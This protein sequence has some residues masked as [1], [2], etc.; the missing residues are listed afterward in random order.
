MRASSQMPDGL[1][2][3]FMYTHQEFRQSDWTVQ[4]NVVLHGRV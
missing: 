3:G 4:G 1:F 2:K